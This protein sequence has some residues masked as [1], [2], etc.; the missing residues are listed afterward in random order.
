MELLFSNVAAAQR[1]MQEHGPFEYIV[2]SDLLYGDRA[3]PD[4]L[5]EV[6]AALS[7]A[8][9]GREAQVILAVKNRC[10]DE[11]Q[12]FCRLAKDRG[13]WKIRLADPDDFLEGFNSNCKYG[14]EPS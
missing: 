9:G 1:I 14:D 10:A 7:S 3:P 5:V 8:P 11:A 2:G 13:L 6:L 4:P 12:A